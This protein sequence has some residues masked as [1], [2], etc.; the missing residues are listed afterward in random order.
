MK[1]QNLI[2]NKLGNSFSVM[3]AN[4]EIEIMEKAEGLINIEDNTYYYEIEGINTIHTNNNVLQILAKLY[5]K[6]FDYPLELSFLD[7]GD[8]IAITKEELK[9]KF[10]NEYF[11]FSFVN[12]EPVSIFKLSAYKAK[13]FEF[14]KEEKYIVKIKEE[15]LIKGLLE[16]SFVLYK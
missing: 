1:L 5:S 8:I 3:L 9:G 16:L 10:E 2:F 14:L 7:N 11:V 13:Y 4:P 12:E 6:E 15:N